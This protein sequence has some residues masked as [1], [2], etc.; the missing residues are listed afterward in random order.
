MNWSLFSIY[1]DCDGFSTLCPAE[2]CVRPLY[3]SEQPPVVC[4]LGWIVQMLWPDT[5]FRISPPNSFPPSTILTIW[6][7][8]CNPFTDQRENEICQILYKSSLYKSLF[9]IF[10][11]SMNISI[12]VSHQEY[13]SYHCS[14]YT[15]PPPPCWAA[16]H[17]FIKSPDTTAPPLSK[18]GKRE[19]LSPAITTFW[20]EACQASIHVEM[21]GVRKVIGQRVVLTSSYEDIGLFLQTPAHRYK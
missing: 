17:P 3:I 14:P 4:W 1:G 8:S 5:N 18:G 21:G 11:V 10:I 7:L 9:L 16:P 12:D 19:K 15:S 6:H 13:V 20:R 2:A